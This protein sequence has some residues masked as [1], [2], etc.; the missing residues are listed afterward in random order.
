MEAI[1]WLCVAETRKKAFRSG[2]TLW[3]P[4]RMNIVAR[5][6]SPEVDEAILFLAV[7]DVGEPA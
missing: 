1:R 4:D 6:L 5:E 3:R 7:F 2:A